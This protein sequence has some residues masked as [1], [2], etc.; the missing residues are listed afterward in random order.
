MNDIYTYYRLRETIERLNDNS[1][2][3]KMILSIL[4]DYIEKL[5]EGKE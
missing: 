1:P 3:V 4:D 2:Y 5:K